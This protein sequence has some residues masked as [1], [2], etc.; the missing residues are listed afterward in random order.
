MQKQSATACLKLFFAIAVIVFKH[1]YYQTRLL[2]NVLVAVLEANS[3]ETRSHVL[4][5]RFEP[6]SAA[7]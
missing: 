5:P 7:L 4:K 6:W 1:V 3:R 2:P